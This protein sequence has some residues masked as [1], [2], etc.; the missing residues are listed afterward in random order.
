MARTISKAL[1][2]DLGDL[3]SIAALLQS[4][5]RGRDKI[6][7]H[8]T[9]EEAALL[10]A[11][12]GRGSENPDTGLLEFEPEFQD[13][14]A[15]GMGETPAAPAPT[16]IPETPVTPVDITQ[17][18]PAQ[19]AAPFQADFAQAQQAQAP[20][21]APTPAGMQ[22]GADMGYQPP[23]AFTP[24]AGGAPTA[25][26]ETDIGKKMSDVLGIEKGTLGKLGS[27]ALSALPGLLMQRRG[28]AQAKQAQAEQQQMAAPY[29]QRAQELLSA[30]QSGQ[31]SPA[32]QQQL[33]AANARLQQEAAAR[34]GV[35]QAQALSQVET[36]RQQLLQQ[37]YDLGLQLSG[38]ADQISLGAIKT[39]FQASQELNA[40]QTN[41]FNKI[42]GQ[43][44]AQK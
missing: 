44:G 38:I 15:M 17:Q 4:K 41:L 3:R 34:G 28:A 31:L 8:I 6:L 27:T 32:A 43:L 2:T 26:P 42:F 12:G 7:A 20:Q 24:A 14:E 39:G 40:A 22:Y 21:A 33:Q 25:Q 5:G 10:K 30:S 37:Q 1:K 19:E 36:L 9:K 23:P 16:T 29:R 11:R 18:P 35:G 13:Y